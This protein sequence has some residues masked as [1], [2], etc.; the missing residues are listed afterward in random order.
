MGIEW[1]CGHEVTP[2]PDTPTDRVKYSAI[3][4]AARTDSAPHQ[5]NPDAL[6][7]AMA[8]AIG[9][10]RENY[11]RSVILRHSEGR[12]YEEIAKIMGVPVGTVSTYLTRARAELKAALA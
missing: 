6:G 7:P 12:S 1:R 5:M 8:Q 2:P 11:R 4:V 9:R 3:Q 10:L